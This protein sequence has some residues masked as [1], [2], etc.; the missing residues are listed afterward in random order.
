M[1]YTI[2]SE[3]RKH[4]YIIKLFYIIE[5]NFFKFILPCIGVGCRTV[6]RQFNFWKSDEIKLPLG[7]GETRLMRG[8]VYIFKNIYNIIYI[9]KRKTEREKSFAIFMACE[10]L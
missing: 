8:Q 6:A 10:C 4:K 7:L 3:Y 9:Y 2:L 5:V 1:R